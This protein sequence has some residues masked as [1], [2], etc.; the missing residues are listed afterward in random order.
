MRL[1]SQRTESVKGGSY[2]RVHRL[3]DTLCLALARHYSSLFEYFQLK[4]NIFD[5]K[6]D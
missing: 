3:S 5:I 1:K 4:C 2:S 6:S